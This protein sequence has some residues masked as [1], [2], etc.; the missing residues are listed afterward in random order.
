MWV[1]KCLI[2]NGRLAFDVHTG[3]GANV[4]HIMPRVEGGDD[5][6]RNV[7]LTHPRCNSEKGRHWD[8]PKARS[9]RHDPERYTVLVQGFL[10]RRKARWRDE[11]PRLVRRPTPER[12]WE[13]YTT[14]P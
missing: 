7:G 1:G 14:E 13:S 2:C 9:Q 6:L 3:F 8:N 11:P 4:E 12:A 5:D 10:D